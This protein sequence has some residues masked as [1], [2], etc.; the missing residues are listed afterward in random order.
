M[1]FAH[2]SL[3]RL[4]YCLVTMVKDKSPDISLVCYNTSH[5]ETKLDCQKLYFAKL[6]LDSNQS[7]KQTLKQGDRELS[8]AQHNMS[9]D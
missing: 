8:Q 5:T 1:A 9:K 4:L 6:S 3:Q 7:W 2:I